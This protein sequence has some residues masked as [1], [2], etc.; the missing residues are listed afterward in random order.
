MK[1]PSLKVLFIAVALV[2][3]AFTVAICQG[4]DAGTLCKMCFGSAA[5]LLGATTTTAE[6]NQLPQESRA[7][8]RTVIV[9]AADLTDPTGASVQTIA[10]AI[11]A[12]SRVEDVILDLWDVF[13]DDSDTAFDDIT[14]SVKDNAGT[15]IVF[16][17]DTQIGASAAIR[18][19][20][21]NKATIPPQTYAAAA[22]LNLAFTP[23]S[24]KA[25]VNLDRGEVRIHV[26]LH[27][28]KEIG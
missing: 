21:M 20:A 5:L 15:P 10:I 19:A 25:L 16:I 9:K 22:V 6:F 12:W 7:F 17:A 14:V 3:L 13:R 27:K 2:A 11:P 26:V 23:E 18:L 24:G 8:T 4:A 1:I 28:H